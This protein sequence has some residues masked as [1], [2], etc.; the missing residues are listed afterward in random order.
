MASLDYF[1]YNYT[2]AS[3]DTSSG[4]DI[5]PAS[6]PTQLRLAV[7]VSGS[8]SY[9][10]EIEHQV[11]S[12]NGTFVTTIESRT[13]TAGTTYVD[14]KARVGTAIGRRYTAILR[15]PDVSAYLGN[16]HVGIRTAATSFIYVN[17]PAGTVHDTYAT[18]NVN[19]TAK[20]G[21]P[22]RNNPGGSVT[23]TRFPYT[24]IQYQTAKGCF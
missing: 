12:G 6:I 3:M 23:P 16:I 13:F 8:G 21:L 14:I 17:D 1:R 5:N 20:F 24:A 2:G 19:G 7:T 10:C 4:F 11:D 18:K 15:T 9:P 22:Y